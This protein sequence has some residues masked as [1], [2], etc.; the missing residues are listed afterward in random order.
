MHFARQ[1]AEASLTIAVVIAAAGMPCSAQPV[2]T[3]T[4]FYRH[5]NSDACAYCVSGDGTVVGGYAIPPN[6]TRKEPV[7]WTRQSGILVY[8]TPGAVD[9]AEIRALNQNGSVGVGFGFTPSGNMRAIRWSPIAT[10]L[11]T[12][13]PWGLAPPSNQALGV[14][15]DGTVVVGTSFGKAFRW[16]QATGLVDLGFYS[17]APEYIAIGTCVTGDGSTVFGAGSERNGNQSIPP[18]LAFRW[19]DGVMQSLGVT[20]DWR[21]SGVQAV[22]PDGFV[23]MGILQ[24]PINGP[25]ARGAFRWKFGVGME[26]INFAP[27]AESTWVEAWDMT[28]DGKTIVGYHEVPTTPPLAEAHAVIWTEAGGAKD[29]HN[30]LTSMGVMPAGR[31]FEI[32]TGISGDGTVIVGRS[33]DG[34]RWRGI[35]VDFRGDADGDG[36]LDHW[37]IN[38]IPYI[39]DLGQAK[40]LHLPGADPAH[41]DLYLEIDAMAGMSIPQESID[42]VVQAFADAPLAN[43]DGTTGVRLHVLVDEPDLEHRPLWVTSPNNCWPADFGTYYSAHF[44][45]DAER[46]ANGGAGPL[47]EAARAKAYRYCIIADAASPKDWGGCGLTPGDKSVVFVGHMTEAIDKAAALMHEL[48]HN[49]GLHHGGNQS[50]QGKPNYP[51]IMNYTLAYRAEWNDLFW[52]LDY[53]R[54]GALQLGNLNEASLDETRGIGASNSLYAE[55]L[56]PIGVNDAT[57]R[58]LSFVWLDGSPFDFGNAAGTGIPD[59]NFTT[60]VAQD[61]NYLPSPPPEIFLPTA[62]SPGESLTAHNDWA[63]VILPTPAA[64]GPGAPLGV[65]PADELTISAKNWIAQNWHLPGGPAPC[66]ANCDGSTIPPVINIA[67]FACFLNRFA[68]GNSYANCDGSTTPP[69]LNVQ[70]FSCFLNAFAAGCS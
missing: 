58:T 28:D 36:L 66:Y 30:I 48:G 51:S 55:F 4:E 5:S 53:S 17:A 45:T 12:L 10:D 46:S 69:V 39:N 13:P 54:E 65:P 61:L 7:M 43:P 63:N 15:A 42:L 19:H 27:G 38:G 35:V 40:R 59:G 49:L 16:T 47:F 68:S 8:G 24:R 67:D 34:V 33:S 9:R 32:A 20:G 21:D 3:V 31:R 50:I 29:L 60:S 41:K 6:G 52:R 22:T 37:E 62:P 1:S 11:N 23:A 57:G 56:M 26:E 44:G 70:D 64:I 14:S 2:P 25:G 18:G